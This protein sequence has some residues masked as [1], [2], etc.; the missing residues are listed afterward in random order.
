MTDEI[1]EL[2]KKKAWLQQD[3]R[4][5]F[6][7]E[8]VANTKQRHTQRIY[9]TLHNRQLN[10]GKTLKH[11]LRNTGLPTSDIVFKNLTS[12]HIITSLTHRTNIIFYI[13]HFSNYAIPSS[14][15]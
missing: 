2:K 4:T 1:E 13:K 3:I 7:Q 11:T 5:L 10:Y 15:Y 8:M 9:T 6:H 14:N 12:Q